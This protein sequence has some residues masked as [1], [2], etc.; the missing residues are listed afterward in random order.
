VVN[1]LLTSYISFVAVCLVDPAP[2]ISSVVDPTPPIIRRIRDEGEILGKPFTETGS[3]TTLSR[4]RV[5][6]MVKCTN[7]ASGTHVTRAERSV[8][9]KGHPTLE[10]PEDSGFETTSIKSAVAIVNTTG[11]I[12]PDTFKVAL[13]LQRSAEL[14]GPC[15]NDL[16]VLHIINFS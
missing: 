3:V 2:V 13:T 8:E 4:L 14:A 7:A 1:L 11:T 9:T 10:S 5:A 16:N 6:I 15:L 12:A